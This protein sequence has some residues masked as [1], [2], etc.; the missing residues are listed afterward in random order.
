MSVLG[1]LI[2]RSGTIISNEAQMVL[3]RMTALTATESNAIIRFINAE[4][5]SMGN[6]NWG[7]ID[8]FWIFKLTT[9]ANA[10]TGWKSKIATNNGA[11]LGANGFV[12]D[13]STSYI[14]SNFNP[15]IDAVQLT[16]DNGLT[17]SH[18]YSH[19]DNGAANDIFSAL[20][21]NTNNNQIRFILFDNNTL[22][23]S[24]INSSL[25]QWG[26]AWEAV[27]TDRTYISKKSS[28]LPNEIL[29]YRDGILQTDTGINPSNRN[30]PN[31]DMYIGTLNLNGASQV[32]YFEGTLSMIAIGA[33]IGFNAVAFNTNVKTLLADL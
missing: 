11:V 9:E 16:R 28:S 25:N 27:V 21:Q 2:L 26:L 20:D 29:L 6:G 4:S 3:D 24:G 31:L 7:L 14:N 18:V 5:V 22:I 23:E 10:L 17:S 12:F 13:G 8:E 15:I 33:A 1:G 32:A 19:L 30:I